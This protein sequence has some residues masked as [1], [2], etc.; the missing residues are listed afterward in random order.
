MEVASAKTFTSIHQ[1]HASRAM[2]MALASNVSQIQC[3]ANV[4]TLKDI[5][6]RLLP[7]IAHASAEVHTPLSTISAFYAAFQDV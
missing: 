6:K 5:K 1:T 7:P 3:V 2:L 4:I